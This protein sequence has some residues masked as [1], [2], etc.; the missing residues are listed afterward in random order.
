MVVLGGAV[1]LTGS[2]LSMVDWQPLIGAIP[3]LDQAA[4]QKLFEDYQQ[5]PEF[6]LVNRDMTLSGFKF[7]FLMEYA[8]RVLGRLI[9][10]VFLLPFI[11]FA[12]TAPVKAK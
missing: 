12:F 6:Q 5:F 11:Y 7:I 1:R 2:G 3:P 10:L 9:G 8:H 4:W